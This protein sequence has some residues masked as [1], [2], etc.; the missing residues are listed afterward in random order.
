MATRLKPHGK[1]GDPSAEDQ[2][3]A[4]KK[5][6]KDQK[7]LEKKEKQK[8][9]T[10]NIIMSYQTIRPTIIQAQRI[11]KILDTLKIKFSIT[12]SLNFDFVRHFETPETLESSKL[13]MGRVNRLAKHTLASLAKIASLQRKMHELLS[14]ETAQESQAGEEEQEDSRRDEDL[15]DDDNQEVRERKAKEEAERERIRQER[16]GQVMYLKEKM[17]GDFNNLVRQLERDQNEYAII[18]VTSCSNPRV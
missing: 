7:R 5:G 1:A 17:E 8:E 14:Q 9:L 3:K 11:L 13:D 4:H 10:D 15:D 18:R 6:E 16:E 12:Q 2:A